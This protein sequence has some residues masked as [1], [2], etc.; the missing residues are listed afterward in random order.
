MKVIYLDVHE[1]VQHVDVCHVDGH[2]KLW[3][4]SPVLPAVMLNLDNITTM[5]PK[6][7]I[8]KI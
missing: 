8:K 2:W 1:D 7:Y 4:S 6:N 5:V 3:Q